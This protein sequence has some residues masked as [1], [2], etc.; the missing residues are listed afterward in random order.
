MESEKRVWGIH[1]RDDLLFLNSGVIAI[2]WSQ[3]GDLSKITPDREAFREKIINR[4]GLYY[5][6]SETWIPSESLYEV[7]YQMEV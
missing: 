6:K 3:L 5:N 1:T 2:G 7:L 4:N